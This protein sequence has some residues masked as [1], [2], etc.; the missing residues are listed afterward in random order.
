[1]KKLLILIPILVVL[2]FAI[3]WATNIG[4]DMT[5]EGA[6]TF[7][8]SQITSWTLDT[9]NVTLTA[10]NCGEYHAIATDAKTYTLPTTIAGCEYTFIN[11]GADD[12]VLLTIT[13]N[14]S[15]ADKIVGTCAAVVFTGTDD[16]DV[17]NT[18]S[19]ANQ[20]DWIRI[21]GDGNIGWTTIGCDGVWAGA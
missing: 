11:M 4:D 18:K 5:Y 12:A 3:A 2:L 15:V 21:I 1:M 8:G 6:V 9:D 7:S 20:G 13:P 17:T 16:G 10:S 19:G 14:D